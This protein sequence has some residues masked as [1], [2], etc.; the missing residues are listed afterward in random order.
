LP[1]GLPLTT[2]NRPDYH[3]PVSRLFF[4]LCFKITLKPIFRFL[5]NSW[6]I[7]Q[8]LTL[9]LELLLKK[10]LLKLRS[11]VLRLFSRRF[12][13]PGLALLV[14]LVMIIVH[15]GPT[16]AQSMWERLFIQGLQVVQLSNISPR[17]EIGIG[18]QINQQF[19]REGMRFVDDPRLNDYV[20]SMGERLVSQSERSSIPY[21]FQIV[22][23]RGVNAFATMGG[24]VYVTTGLMQTADNEAQVASVIGHEIG[25]IEGR[26]LIRQMRQTAVTRGM[27]TAAGLD[28]SRAV[29]LGAELGLRRPRSRQDEFDADQRGLRMLARAGYAESAMPAFMRKLVRQV[30]VPTALST[31]PGAA[32]RANTLERAIQERPGNSCRQ[33]GNTSACGLDADFYRQVVQERLASTASSRT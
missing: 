15:P 20:R 2:F 10:S 33:N 6:A 16:L 11:P 1:E 27:L 13:Y 30:S 5:R 28:N 12:V 19:L 7:M 18:Q 14:A 4:S 3:N 23:D 22:R 26:H 25:H 17:Q 29:S 8:I 31:H 32:E 21:T 24:F 9:P